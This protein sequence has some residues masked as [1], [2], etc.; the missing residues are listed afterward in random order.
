MIPFGELAPDVADLNTTVAKVAHNVIP[1]VNAYHPL[2]SLAVHSDA[3][4]EACRGAITP[5]D[6]E[7]NNYIFAGS[8]QYLYSIA[9]GA[10]TDESKVG[11]YTNNSEKWSF[12][13]WGE[14]IVAAKM[15]DTPQVITL[16]GSTFA[17]LAGSP[18]QCRTMTTIKNFLVMANTWD[19]TDG[20]KANRVWWSGY[21]D[22]EGW[23]P[24]TNQSDWQD[25]QGKG[26]DIQR[27]VGGE[28]GIIFQERAI[29]RM[30]YVGTPL[31]FQFDEVEPGIGTPAGGSVVQH[32][33]RIFFLGQDGFYAMADGGGPTPI[34]T[35][36]IDR[37]FYANLNKT[38]AHNMSAAIAPE[39][40]FVVWSYPSSA[41]SGGSCDSLI[42]FNYK[43]GR[44]ATGSLDTQLL[45]QG[46][47]SAYT[48]ED[49][50]S[51]GDLDALGSSLDSSAWQ[52]GA[53]KLAA[54]NSDNKMGF[55]SGAPMVGVL[56]TA[57][58]GDNTNRSQI[59]SVR[60]LIDGGCT[61]S[62]SYRDNLAD[63]ATSTP[64]RSVDSTGKANF[65][66]N[67]RYH[68]IQVT[69]T[70]EFTEALGVEPV[71]VGK[72]KR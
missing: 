55:F 8:A 51:F 49:L 60:P 40:G 14:K 68:R 63:A 64:E 66:T 44:W 53:Y 69:T 26:G 20:Y 65:R 57:E 46:A 13:Q 21:E 43:S 70:G 11:G 5:K 28:Y 30:S 71:V 42:A 59:S 10:V 61:V 32:G 38:F 52:G 15:G 72:G 47:T 29:W 19:S 27:I 39:S 36:K 34:G 1:G 33:S 18:P 58:I 31:V 17:D 54:F 62:L 67:A 7:G 48:L 4:T 2:P 3:L 45:L 35:Q 12:I 6:F 25:I 23:T 56:Q 50:D 24:A 37:W 16:G 9:A 41:S 22:I